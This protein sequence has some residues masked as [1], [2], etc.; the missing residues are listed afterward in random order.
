MNFGGPREAGPDLRPGDPA[1]GPVGFQDEHPAI[2]FQNVF[3][4][5]LKQ[6]PATPAASLA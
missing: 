5:K 6:I 3:P 2:P 4:R 1:Q